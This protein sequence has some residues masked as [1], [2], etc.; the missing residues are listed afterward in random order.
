MPPHGAAAQGQTYQRLKQLP[1]GSW[2]T[3]VWL[4]SKLQ[5]ASSSERTGGFWLSP[6]T[7]LN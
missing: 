6:V 1:A 3:E 7:A 2:A 4:T 5:G